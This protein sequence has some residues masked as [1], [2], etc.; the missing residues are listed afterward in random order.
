MDC[1]ADQSRGINSGSTSAL[2]FTGKCDEK[3][4]CVSPTVARSA[5][6]PVESDIS[7]ATTF[8]PKDHDPGITNT[9]ML[10]PMSLQP[11][12]FTPV[13]TSG[14]V[15]GIEIHHLGASKYDC[16]YHIF[17]PDT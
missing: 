12:F 7:T 3:N 14:S 10:F 9:A 16:T 8:K 1:N 15:P 2:V 17:Q 4:I 6:N 13:R 11:N 5:Q